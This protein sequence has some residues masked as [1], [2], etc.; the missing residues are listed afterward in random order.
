M[1]APYQNMVDQNFQT[2]IC[3][4]QLFEYGR[5]IVL[6]QFLFLLQIASNIELNSRKHCPSCWYVQSHYK[7]WLCSDPVVCFA[8]LITVL[9][10]SSLFV[11][12]SIIQVWSIIGNYQKICHGQ[13]LEY[14][15]NQFFVDLP[16]MVDYQNMVDYSVQQSNFW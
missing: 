8:D 10:C 1:V 12:W 2:K 4:G 16:P 14:G 6:G 9:L 5:F 11:L 13:L 15:R 7:S 3:Y